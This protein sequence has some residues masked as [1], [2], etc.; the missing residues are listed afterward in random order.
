LTHHAD[1]IDLDLARSHRRDTHMT[2]PQKQTV[3]KAAA[4]ELKQRSH[5]FPYPIEAFDFVREGLSFTVQRV[6][7]NPEALPE[8]DRHICGQ[9]LCLGL[10]DFAIEQ[11]GYL[12]PLVLGHWNIHRTD[13]FGRIV[14]LLV[15][16]GMMSKTQSDHI[17]DFRAVYDFSEAFA[18]SE[19]LGRIAAS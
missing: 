11:Y 19:L 7:E 1:I 13:D 9:Q 12:A 8:A 14:F 4:P 16:L 18:E 2:T 15:D 6:H 17:D 5:S 3:V 10:R